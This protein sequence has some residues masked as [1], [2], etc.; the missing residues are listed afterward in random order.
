MNRKKLIL[1][2]SFV[3]ILSINSSAQVYEASTL[4]NSVSRS[5]TVQGLFLDRWDILQ[6]KNFYFDIY[7]KINWVFGFNVNTYNAGAGGTGEY[8]P[9]D[10]NLVRS[11]GSMTLALPLGKHRESPEQTDLIMAFT[12]TGFH[13]GLTKTLKV[14]RGSAGTETITD[15]KHSQFFDDIYAL[16]MLWRPYLTVHA[17]IIVNNEYVPEEEGTISYFDPEV[18]YRKYF[19]ALEVMGAAGYSMNLDDGRPESIK[20]DLT[21]NPLI[22]FFGV[23][24]SIYFPVIE[25]GFEYSAAYNDEPFDS[26]WV[27]TPKD[28]NTD[29]SK[30]KAKLLLLNLNIT[31]RLSKN[32]TVEGSGSLQYITKNIYGRND[33]DKID[34]AKSKEWYILLN[35][36]PVRA[37]D[38]AGFKAYTGMSRY[39]D[40]AVAIHRKKPEKGS[41]IYG[42]IIGAEFDIPMLGAGLVAQRNFSRELRMLAET[43]DKWSIEGNIFFRI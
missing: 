28:I 35:I 3:L 29:Y 25:T 11:Y 7:G 20:V 19:L 21:L 30:D 34:P 36:D 8:E 42:W 26:V 39:W 16:S 37:A 14:E 23:N 41:D 5:D 31:Q 13:Y 32:F 10:L 2:L 27:K 12:A 1:I 15:Y 33:G 9:T 18:H 24:Q 43:A 6:G 40:P 4:H 17:G 22:A 38:A